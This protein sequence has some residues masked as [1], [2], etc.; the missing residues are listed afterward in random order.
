MLTLCR[1]CLDVCTFAVD[2]YHSALNVERTLSY[3]YSV[4]YISAEDLHIGDIAFIV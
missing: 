2:A 4:T 3:F 1:S